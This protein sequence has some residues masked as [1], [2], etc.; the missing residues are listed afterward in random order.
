[1]EEVKKERVNS[2]LHVKKLQLH[3]LLQITKAIN[4]NLPAAQLF[5]IYE[6]VMRDQLKVKK[7][8]L[9][10]H[11]HCWH[12]MLSYG[13]T[14]DEE[15]HNAE[16]HFHELN[17]LQY[18]NLSMPA[19]VTGFDSIIPVYHNDHALAYAFIGDLQHEEISSLKEVLPFIHT[20]TN[21]IVVAI[22]N[23]RLTRDAIRQAQLQRE[24]ELAARMQNM[25][26]PASLPV[27]RQ[28]EMAATYLPHQQVGGDYYDYIELSEDELL[29]CL[30]DVSGK[31]IS[32]ALLMSNFQ[33]NLNARAKTSAN[34][35]D[36]ITELNNN[37]NRSAKGEKYI[38]VFLA[39]LNTKTH[40]IR[41]V[42]AGHNPPVIYNKGKFSLLEEGTTGLGMFEELP[43][44]NEGL[45]Y[46]SPGSV[47][48]C[49]TDG[50][51]EQENNV[52]EIFGLEKLM[53]LIGMHVQKSSLEELHSVVLNEF[54]VFRG[55]ADALDDVTLLSCR[56][57][58]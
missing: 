17:V 43:F 11:E 22:E 26:F 5:E 2:E 42:N 57:V 45:A 13:I 48:F 29:I 14:K 21:I 24:L 16:D 10:V 32:A 28:L 52:S 31:G 8:M 36:L 33:A 20:I 25:L 23:K 47:L 4:Y 3:W 27:H 34:L 6:T 44:L 58:S 15:I 55:N 7:L 12:R 53:E 35:S 39:L 50:I 54:N 56:I 38:T 37:V 49:Y 19:W 46:L 41:Y 1:M 18:N 40:L 51:V 30:A 9:Y